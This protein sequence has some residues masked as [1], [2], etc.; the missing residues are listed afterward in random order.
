MWRHFI[1]VVLVFPLESPWVLAKI[2]DKG[3]KMNEIQELSNKELESINGG[4]VFLVVRG[5]A[6]VGGL[7][8]AGYTAGKA[9]AEN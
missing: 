1:L 9:I 4:W 3:K 8:G 6:A 5:I 7:F 2:H